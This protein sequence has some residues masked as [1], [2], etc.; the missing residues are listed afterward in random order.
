MQIFQKRKFELHG[1]TK[2]WTMITSISWCSRYDKFG[3]FITFDMLNYTWCH[4][5][6]DH[7]YVHIFVL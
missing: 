2:Y 7:D 5:V 1:V 4:Q 3:S 6:L